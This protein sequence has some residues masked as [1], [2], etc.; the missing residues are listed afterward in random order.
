MVMEN[1]INILDFFKNLWRKKILIVLSTFVIF[2]I[3]SSLLIST[4]SFKKPYTIYILPLKIAADIYKNV[5]LDTAINEVFIKKVLIDAKMSHLD[6]NII[7]KK[8]RI[9][10]GQK[11]TNVVIDKINEVN[12]EKFLK[13]ILVNS[14]SLE[15]EIKNLNAF[16]QNYIEVS[17][18][19]FDTDKISSVQSKSII[20]SFT[21]N[22]S[23]YIKKY[24]AS[25]SLKKINFLN[26]EKTLSAQELNSV[27]E[28]NKQTILNLL[29]D[30]NKFYKDISISSLQFNNE[31][32]H[33]K[34]MGLIN[35]FPAH[36]NLMIREHVIKKNLNLKKVE[37]IDEIINDLENN[38]TNFSEGGT[39][40]NEL[41]LSTEI[42]NRLLSLSKEYDFADLK[43]DL[44]NEKQLI[45]YD[46]NEIENMIESMN[47]NTEALEILET[48]NLSF[49]ENSKLLAESINKNI[50]LIND[51]ISEVNL[52]SKD[53]KL[54][55]F[56]NYRIEKI[57]FLPERI[58]IGL[59]SIF[60]LS[61]FS[62]IVISLIFNYRKS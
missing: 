49:E 6:A 42:I 34:L 8:I 36:K 32:N 44:L 46:V 54:E 24:Y 47:Y 10:Q 13:K 22:L 20:D 12:A 11:G 2:V 50:T 9:N 52:I 60:V 23:I 56:S 3:L 5:N 21:K 41:L 14:N 19:V 40:D 29:K 27:L 39:S 45:Q 4:L 31:S 35:N 57:N 38:L 61:L 58:F 59:I 17:F 18:E 48:N 51:Y 26:L 43:I 15:S 7:S 37:I 28:I 1:D 53:N 33:L 62:S 25:N 30:Y 55:K 16:N